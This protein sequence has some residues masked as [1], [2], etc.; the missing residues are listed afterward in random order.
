MTTRHDLWAY[1]ATLAAIVTLTGI[2]AWLASNGKLTEA[3]GTGAA[4]TGLIGV[5]RMPVAQIAPHTD[6]G[7]INVGA[8][9]EKEK[10]I[11]DLTGAELPEGGR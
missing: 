1:M 5:M 11:L 10:D 3:V 4:I 2:A 7:N 6:S 9:P 8:P